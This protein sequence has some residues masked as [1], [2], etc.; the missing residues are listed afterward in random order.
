MP[1]VRTLLIYLPTSSL[2]LKTSLIGRTLFLCGATSYSLVLLHKEPFNYFP[3]LIFLLVYILSLC[4][5]G[6]MRFLLKKPVLMLFLACILITIVNIFLHPSFVTNN[7]I[8]RMQY[9]A[10]RGLAYASLAFATLLIAII[11]RPSDLSRLLG[12]LSKNPRLI[13]ISS[14]PFTIFSFLA[15]TLHDILT[16]NNFR[17]YQVRMIK[18]VFFIVVNTASAFLAIALNRSLF[19]FQATHGWKYPPENKR[20]IPLIC[21]GNIL[22]LFDIVFII[23][24]LPGVFFLWI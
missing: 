2:G 17:I 21:N 10:T 6:G 22:S 16:A 1:K 5:F 19:L 12:R 14:I 24:L 4:G 20:T 13:M 3:H 18:R 7:F 23:I 15:T 11:T 8:P 9:G